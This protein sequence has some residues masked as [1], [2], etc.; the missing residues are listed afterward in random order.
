[1]KIKIAAAQYPI[2]QYSTISEWKKNIEIWIKNAAE[3][4]AEILL[5][6]EFASLELVSL[7]PPEIQKRP[8]LFAESLQS[9]LPEF[10]TTFKELAIKYKL[11][12]I[13]P[14]FPVKENKSV[15]NRVYVFGITGLSSY[16][17]KLFLTNLDSNTLGIV[18]PPKRIAIFKTTK[19]TFGIQICYDSEF[20]IGSKYLAQNGV[21]ILLIPSCTETIHGANRIHLSARARALEQQFYTVV[22][23]VVGNATWNIALNK[24][25]G[26]AAYYAVPDKYFTEDGILK[27]GEPQNENWLIY[28]IDT[29]T[30]NSTRE[31]GQISTFKDHLNIKSE[32]KFDKINLEEVT[33]G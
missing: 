24:N 15:F 26:Y 25:F 9:F 14:S 21:E 7:L 31:S 30:I 6:P 2:K 23:Q 22:S 33:I 29:S 3:Q 20:S 27:S 12:I 10:T 11:T 8:A 28:Q 1:M 5:F 19:C 32:F 18:S 16:Q 13:A 4:N 17:D